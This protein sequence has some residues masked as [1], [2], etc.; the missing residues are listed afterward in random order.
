M[1]LRSKVS[2]SSTPPSASA[3]NSQL[4][5]P[6]R[7]WLEEVVL[8]LE[9]AALDAVDQVAQEL[10][11]GLDD[12]ADHAG[13][14]GE[15]V[16]EHRDELADRVDDRLDRADRL[17]DQAPVLGLQLLDP[18]VETLARL[19]VLGGQGVDHATPAWSRPRSRAARTGRRSPSTPRSRPSS[20]PWAGSSRTSEISVL[21]AAI[22]CLG[23]GQVVADDVG[24]LGDGLVHLLEVELAAGH[25]EL[26]D[27]VG[28]P[29]DLVPEPSGTCRVQPPYR[30]FLY[31]DILAE[32]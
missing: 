5:R 6:L 31:A 13:H 21:P 22:R 30:S 16:L 15:H 32:T 4:I 3:P 19:D 23:R 2:G 27:L 7:R 10:H 29:L 14:P 18:L 25:V 20:G 26:V 9:D 17:V 8:E 24:D 12:L 28:H 1:P 11:R